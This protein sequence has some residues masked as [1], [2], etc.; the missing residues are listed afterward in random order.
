MRIPCLLALGSLAVLGSASNCPS[1]GRK[2]IY[3]SYADINWGDFGST[4][5]SAA[6]A[7]YNVLIMSFYVS[8]AHAAYDSAQV[9][10]SLGAGGQQDALNYVHGKGGCVLLSVGGAT[11]SPF[12]LDPNSLGNEVGQYANNNNYD[13]IDFDIENINPGF[14]AN[15]VDAAQWLVD[16]TNSAR[17]VLGGD[18]TITHAPQGPY[19]GPVGGNSWTGSSGGYSSIDGKTSIDWYNVQ[20]YNQGA[21]CYVDYSGLFQSSCSNFPGTSVQEIINNGG[22]PANKIVVGKPVTGADGGSGF[23][24]GG[25]FGNLLRQA[26]SSGIQIGGYMGW[27]WIH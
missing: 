19:F 4:V 14:T 25:T 13:G 7:G 24:D 27:K 3:L 2:V 12:S 23:I 18:K 21:S 11:D 8:T 16:V 10:Q 6:D 22:I 20:F 5:R 17:N 1:S 9:W 15:G 26:E